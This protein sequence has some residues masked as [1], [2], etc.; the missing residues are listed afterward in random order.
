MQFRW[1][2]A[3]APPPPHPSS[4][5]QGNISSPN[6]VGEH[7]Q[8]MVHQMQENSQNLEPNTRWPNSPLSW[9]PD[10]ELNCRCTHAGPRKA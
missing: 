6:L 5:L 1:N 3:K 10:L 2:Q 9:F 8:K 4:I 7:E